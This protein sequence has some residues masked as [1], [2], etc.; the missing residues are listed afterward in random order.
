MLFTALPAHI[1]AKDDVSD[2]PALIIPIDAWG[3]VLICQVEDTVENLG[4]F[5][6]M[7]PLQLIGFGRALQLRYIP[8]DADVRAPI[9]AIHRA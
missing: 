6:D 3:A 9:T 2:T 7:A 5:P 4:P 8:A 1:R